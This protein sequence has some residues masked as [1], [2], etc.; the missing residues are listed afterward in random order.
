[1]QG[2]NQ[3]TLADGDTVGNDLLGVLSGAD[4]GRAVTETVAEVG[5]VAE[6][7]DVVGRAAELLGLASS[8]HVVGAGLLEGVS[9]VVPC[10]S[11]TGPCRESTYTAGSEVRDVLGRGGSGQSAEGE[12]SGLHFDRFALTH[13]IY[14]RMWLAGAQTLQQD[15]CGEGAVQSLKRSGGQ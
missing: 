10:G 3:L 11:D 8:H 2:L 12:E 14:E 6:A 4:G 13:G 15:V 7:L 9:R 1:M 5:V